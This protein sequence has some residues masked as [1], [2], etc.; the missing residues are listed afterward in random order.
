MG[1]TVACG[2]L[3]GITM[4]KC[5]FGDIEEWLERSNVRQVVIGY[6]NEDKSNPDLP[7][8]QEEKWKRFDA[9][10]W[11]RFLARQLAK[12]GY[13]GK[14]CHLPDAWRNAAGQADWDGR[15]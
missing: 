2:A 5:L 15:L 10:V 8:Y 6:D 4:A 13:E 7:G 1:G 12:E 3:P 14:V 9:E 11:A